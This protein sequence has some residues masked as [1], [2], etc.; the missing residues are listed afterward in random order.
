VLPPLGEMQLSNGIAANIA[1]L[2]IKVSITILSYLS[3][4]PILMSF[5]VIAIVF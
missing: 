5:N 1:D 3:A 2:R 4:L